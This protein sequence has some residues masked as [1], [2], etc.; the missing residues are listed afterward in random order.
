MI[1][2]FE[3]SPGTFTHIT[4]DITVAGVHIPAGNLPN[5][6][7]AQRNSVGVFGLE[8]PTPPTGQVLESFTVQ[9]IDGVV[10][11]V[12]AYTAA[13]AP[14]LSFLDFMGLFTAT[15][16]AAI[17]GSNDA[18]VRLF[19]A[20]ATGAQYIDLGD[21]RLAG[22]LDYLTALGILTSG[23]KGEILINQAPA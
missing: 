2:Y 11:I 15:E 16:A 10:Q 8:F 17:A 21:A 20:Q 18:Q 3:S 14:Q 6:D 7:E 12:P 1:F 23:R 22:G 4:G 13:P 9:R 5:W 19:L